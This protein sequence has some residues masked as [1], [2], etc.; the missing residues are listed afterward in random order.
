ME[1]KINVGFFGTRG[2]G[3]YG[4]FETI[5]QK[6]H[7]NIDNQTFN[8]FVSKE[9]EQKNKYEL[10]KINDTTTL[11]NQNTSFLK[12]YSK[13]LDNIVNEGNIITECYKENQWNLDIIFQCGSTPGLW[14]RRTNKRGPL[15]FWN[16][17][18]IEW[19]REKFPLYGRIVLYLSTLRGIKNSHAITVDSKAIGKYLKNMIGNK[20]VYY[21]PS[22]TDLVEDKDVEE[23]ILKKY[24]LEKNNYYVMVGRAVPENHIIEILQ[25]FLKC[26]T[27][28]KLMIITNFGNDSYSEKAIKII[29]ENKDKLVYK[30]PIYNQKELKTIRYFAFTYLHGHSVGGTN[31]SL[32][33]ALGAGNPCICYDVEYNKEVAREAGRYFITEKSFIMAINE[34]EK[35]TIDEYKNIK[36][37]AQQ[38]IIENFT[39]QYISE[40]HEGIIMDI[41]RKNKKITEKEFDN[42]LNKKYFKEKLIK[43]KFNK[44]M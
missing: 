17:D 43:Y 2:L 23:N 38:I 14:M 21:L 7:E 6:L 30:G 5:A 10:E 11:I 31:P 13:Y 40:V 25:Y 34:I 19:K 20:L 33:E 18:G 44:L 37:I 35:L 42:W 41:L 1:R 32:L 36:E 4:G 29:N 8:L 27:N 39:W 9:R 3:N 22:G 15:L 24:H 16:P 26:E 12:K 28:K